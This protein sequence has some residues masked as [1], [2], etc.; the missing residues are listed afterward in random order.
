MADLLPAAPRQVRGEPV[1][2]GSLAD[3]RQA[4][5]RVD[6]A[7]RP[8]RRSDR[9]HL[10]A[11]GRLLDPQRQ[12][13][14]RRPRQAEGR[15]RPGDPGRGARDGLR[16][17]PAQ[18]REGTQPQG[19][20]ARGHPHVPGAR[21]GGG[22]YQRGEV[23][24]PVRV[25][26]LHHARAPV[27]GEQAVRRRRIR[28]D[29]PAR[30]Q[31]PEA[32]ARQGVAGAG[33]AHRPGPR[34]RCG[35]R[36]RR[37]EDQEARDQPSVREELRAGAHH[38][39]HPR[40]QDA[41]VVRAD[42]QEAPREP[43]GVRRGQG[44]LRRH[45]ALIDHAGVRRVTLPLAG[46]VALVTGGT[47]A[48]GQ[49]VTLRLL[50]DGAVVAVP[51][52]VEAERDRLHERVAATD[53]PRLVTEPVD[54]IDLESMV[55]FARNVNQARGRIDVLVAGVGGFAGGS[56]LETDRETWTRMLDL[57]LTSAFSAAKAVLPHMVRVRYGRIVVVAS[58][59]V[60]PPAGGF[61]AY[62]VAKAG[63]IALTQALAQET[64]EQG[65]TVNAVLPSTMDTPANR[66]AMPSSDRKGWVPVDAVADAIAILARP[67]SG[68]ITG[69]LLAI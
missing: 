23:D 49:A 17:P 14:A 13:P 54:V 53:R 33:R 5:H 36:R 44:P 57:N 25:R 21:R 58:R 20:V 52:A 46:Q 2:A 24:V 7:A 26:A 59:A 40:A 10:A 43:R 18:R 15:F 1:P 65:V 48:L 50:T 67:T 68:Y 34:G 47:G 30:R 55:A 16:G 31:V 61:I 8:I 60:V 9:H 56:L 62:T 29:P 28:A 51:Y 39:A 41:P 42:L 27:R 32:V 35:A 12:P 11:A 66:T 38:A 19:E 6:Q 69:T 3:P 22:G 4:T 45:P 63:A 37:G 64:R